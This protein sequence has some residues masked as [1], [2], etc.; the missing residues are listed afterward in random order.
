MCGELVAASPPSLLLP[1]SNVVK[2]SIE[3][4]FYEIC[5]IFFDLCGTQR[6]TDNLLFAS[7]YSNYSK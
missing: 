6:D 3:L 4:R 1:S 5:Y 2:I 7:N